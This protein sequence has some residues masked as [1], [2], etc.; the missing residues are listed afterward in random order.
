MDS[1]KIMFQP[2]IESQKNLDTSIIFV[3]MAFLTCRNRQRTFIFAHQ[4]L[5]ALWS[6]Q[7][8]HKGLLTLLSSL[9]DLLLMDDSPCSPTPHKPIPHLT[10]HYHSQEPNKTKHILRIIFFIFIYEEISEDTSESLIQIFCYGCCE[11]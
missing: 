2:Q 9:S 3:Y 4:P 1:L 5:P 10:G 7:S 11:L 6:T 8:N